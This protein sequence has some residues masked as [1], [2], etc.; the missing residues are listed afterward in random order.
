MEIA[1]SGTLCILFPSS[2]GAHFVTL[3]KNFQY[4]YIYIYNLERNRI[5]TDFEPNN[6]PSNFN[7]GLTL[8]MI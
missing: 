2:K 7:V 3:C 1:F 8:S 6:S 5:I 4:I